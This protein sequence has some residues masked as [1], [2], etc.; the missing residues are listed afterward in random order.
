MMFNG[1]MENL[2]S[3]VE[4]VSHWAARCQSR[5]A[6]ERAIVFIFFF[7]GLMTGCII[8]SSLFGGFFTHNTI[9]HESVSPDGKLKAVSFTRDFGQ[10]TGR[11]IQISI[12]SSDAV[13]QNWQAGNIFVQDGA[14]AQTKWVD[15][16]RLRIVHSHVGAIYRNE[17][18]Y[19]DLGRQIEI[20]DADLAFLSI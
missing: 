17:R 13:L 8:L 12:M 7:C 1:S 5:A 6:Q 20:E 15:D 19:F 4:L 18:R 11:S 9:I 10:S 14:W 3:N 16:K 2:D